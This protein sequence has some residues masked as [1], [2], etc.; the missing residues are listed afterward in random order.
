[1]SR[2]PLRTHTDDLKHH[3]EK[4]GKV[5]DV[6]MKGTFAFVDF[7]DPS[8][9]AKGNLFIFELKKGQII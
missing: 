2:F 7:S 1:V 4:Y 9:A 3:F 5:R 8:E 6:N